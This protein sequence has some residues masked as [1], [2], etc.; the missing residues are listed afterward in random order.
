MVL[1]N[2]GQPREHCALPAERSCVVIAG[3]QLR[4]TGGSHGPSCASKACWMP[5]WGLS[6]SLLWRACLSDFGPSSCG[7]GGALSCSDSRQVTSEE[8]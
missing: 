7:G 5:A 2:H 3:N 1:A 8:H 4:V 6:G